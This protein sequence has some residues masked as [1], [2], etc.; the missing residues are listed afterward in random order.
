[1]K[2]IMQFSPL[3]CYLALLG[4][5][6]LLSTQFSNTIKHYKLYVTFIQLLHVSVSKRHLQV[7]SDTKQCQHRYFNLGST[8]P[9][10]RL[11]KRY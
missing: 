5:N 10:V 6:V 7:A 11:I 3:P 1:M 4:S 9:S 8:I 2:L